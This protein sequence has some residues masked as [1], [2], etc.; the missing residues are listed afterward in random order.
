[1]LAVVDEIVTE[2]KL[3]GV[4]QLRDSSL[5]SGQAGLAVAFA[6][7][8]RAEPDRGYDEVAG[9]YLDAA[10]DQLSA[11]LLPF[12]L[13]GGFTGIAWAASH[14]DRLVGRADD[15][16]DEFASIDD[17]LLELLA[18]PSCDRDYDLIG[19]LSGIGVY[20]L[21]RLPNSRAQE[22]LARVVDQLARLAEEQPGGV[23]WRTPRDLLPPNRQPLRPEGELNL[24]V[25]HGVP[26]A[27]ALLRRLMRR[28][29]RRKRRPGWSIAPWLGSCNSSSPTARMPGSDT[30]PV[31]EIC[32]ARC[33]WPGATAIRAWQP[34]CFARHRRAAMPTGSGLRFEIASDAADRPEPDMQVAD[35]G[36]CHGWAGLLHQYNR[37]YQATGERKFAD[38]ARHC[39]RRTLEA[40]CPGRGIAGYAAWQGGG[41]DGKWEWLGEV[42]LLEGAAGIALALLAAAGDMPPEWDLTFL[43]SNRNLP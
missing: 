8:H 2:L 40:Q 16:A 35:A 20:A 6:Y 4:E 5:A 23:A 34:R 19:G 7:F 33:A 30:T 32:S 43:V 22:I 41:S 31:R 11:A 13:F 28:T 36:L 39:C 1:M 9:A 3:R 18:A 10:I 17:A 25:A 21:E 14:L 12:G 38:F 15:A 26:G 37:L 42:G 29:C 27:V 24:G